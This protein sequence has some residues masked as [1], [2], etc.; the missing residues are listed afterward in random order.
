MKK[1]KAFFKRLFGKLNGWIAK[2]MTVND[3][4]VKK[5]SPIAVDI[6]NFIKEY[7][8]TAI[9]SDLTKFLE[10]LGNPVV[11]G[12]INIVEKILSDKSL[13]KM[14]SVIG[15]AQQTAAGNTPQQKVQIITDYIKS[16]EGDSKKK[17]A[18][19]TL[20]SVIAEILSNG[21]VTWKELYLIVEGIYKKNL[22]KSA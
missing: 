4:A 21:T 3:E 15:I 16:I 8:G 19:T 20:A 18:W 22:N 17:E 11:T 5:Y 9:V 1:I 13:D 12:G 6:I 2:F 14:L 7:N 10:S